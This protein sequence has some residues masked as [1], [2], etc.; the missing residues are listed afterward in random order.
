MGAE[1]LGVPEFPMSKKIDFPDQISNNFQT[2]ILGSAFFF[3][4]VFWEIANDRTLSV[5]S[6]N[7]FAGYCPSDAN[8]E[9]RKSCLSFFFFFN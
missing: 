6:L 3:V 1:A 9:R 4:Y 8:V 5:E 2:K 7:S